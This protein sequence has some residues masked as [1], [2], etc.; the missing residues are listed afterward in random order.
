[1]DIRHRDVAPKDNKVGTTDVNPWGSIGGI[2]TTGTEIILKLSLSVIFGG[3]VGLEREIRARS[4]GLRTHTL[5]CFGSTIFML[6]SQYMWVIYKD[7]AVVDP[8][9]IAAQIITGIGFIGAGTIMKSRFAMKGLT[10]AASIWTVASIGMAVGAGLYYI[11]F[12]SAIG[13]ILI[14]TLLEKVEP[15]LNRDWYVTLSIW[16]IKDDGITEKVKKV[17]TE[18]GG[19]IRNIIIEKDKESGNLCMDINVRYQAKHENE[20]IVGK[21]I[22][23]DG[24]KKVKCE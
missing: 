6:V 19:Q 8:T 4:A 5:V 2:M 14:L 12:V 7:Q 23:I 22:K 9:R 3:M 20:D 11:G 21:I 18:I 17:I 24:V 13:A 15:M 1:V 10:T 16:A